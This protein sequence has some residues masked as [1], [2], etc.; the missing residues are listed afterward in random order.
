MESILVQFGVLMLDT[1]PEV[2]QT[3]GVLASEEA[4]L[5]P[6][7]LAVSV[8]P[9]VSPVLNRWELPNKLWVQAPPAHL[10]LVDNLVPLVDSHKRE[11]WATRGV[12]TVVVIIQVTCVPQGI[13]GNTD[14]TRFISSRRSKINHYYRIRFVVGSPS[15]SSMTT[16]IAKP[17]IITSGSAI[18]TVSAFVLATAT[19]TR[20]TSISSLNPSLRWFVGLMQLGSFLKTLTNLPQLPH[21]IYDLEHP[22]LPISSEDSEVGLNLGGEH[23]LNF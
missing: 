15:T 22:L 5:I 18:P 6:S 10:G 19:V 7:D 2:S 3:T 20:F 13:Q 8:M 17:T 1:N 23:H 16:T 12:I 14:S 9:V 11:T 21:L 4:D